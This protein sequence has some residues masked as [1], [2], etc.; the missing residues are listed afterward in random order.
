MLVKEGEVCRKEG[1]TR[2]KNYSENRFLRGGGK[3]CR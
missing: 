1:K 2:E 3:G